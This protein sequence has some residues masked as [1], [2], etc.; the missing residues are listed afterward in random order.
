MTVAELIK[1][2]ENAPQDYEVGFIAFLEGNSSECFNPISGIE[3]INHNSK[4]VELESYQLWQ[5]KQQ[6]KLKPN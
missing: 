5:Q 6:N 1:E 2:L 4:Q 3:N